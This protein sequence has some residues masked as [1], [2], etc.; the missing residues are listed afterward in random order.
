MEGVLDKKTIT[1]RGLKYQSRFAVLSADYLAFAKTKLFDHDRHNQQ[2]LTQKIDYM[3]SHL[4]TDTTTNMLYDV[5]VRFDQ[6]GNGVLD[7]EEARLALRALHL[8]RDEEDFVILFDHLDADDNGSLDWEEFKMLGKHAS[9]NNAVIDFIP[10]HEIERVEC[11]VET[12]VKVLGDGSS[13]MNPTVF[14]E[15]WDES[16]EGLAGKTKEEFLDNR[17]K[18]PSFWERCV[19]SIENLLGIDLD[20][21]G[22][23]QL[24][25]AIPPYD[26]EINELMMVVMTIETGHNLGRTYTYRLPQESERTWLQNMTQ[27]RV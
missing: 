15:H 4:P 3:I 5:F 10:L 14:R 25:V 1:S 19:T 16:V 17:E 11:V 24:N 27:V 23:A 8:Y 12:K 7:L 22:H 13:P 18:P 26:P 20:G 6:N 21:D 9:A 2:E